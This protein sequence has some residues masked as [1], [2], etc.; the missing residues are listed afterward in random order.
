MS[1]LERNKE[2]VTALYDLMFNECRPADAMER[3]A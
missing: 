2:T 3:C 1:A